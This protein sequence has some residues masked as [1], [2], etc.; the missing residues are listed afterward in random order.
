MWTI[1]LTRLS[2]EVSSCCD[3]EAQT[4]SGEALSQQ[5][6]FIRKSR[7]ISPISKEE[8]VQS[9]LLQWKTYD[10]FKQALMLQRNRRLKSPSAH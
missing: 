10:T 5:N 7:L 3:S 9:S 6:S 2:H 1:I 4:V 8:Q